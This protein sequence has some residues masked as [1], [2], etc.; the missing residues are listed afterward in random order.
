MHLIKE[1][2]HF[3][4]EIYI[5]NK[6]VVENVHGVNYK[7]KTKHKRLEIPQDNKTEV[8]TNPQYK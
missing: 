2:I 1:E 6:N 5:Q 8:T 3:L 7:C 4:K